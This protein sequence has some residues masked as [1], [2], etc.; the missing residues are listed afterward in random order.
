MHTHTLNVPLSPEARMVMLRE[1]LTEVRASL[2]AGPLTF[3]W[4]EVSGERMPVLRID[5][6]NRHGR[7][8]AVRLNLPPDNPVHTAPCIDAL[9]RA[10]SGLLSQSP[11]PEKQ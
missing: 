2:G 10:F 3:T 4:R 9:I 5:I 7:F 1:L 11:S 8:H 6:Y